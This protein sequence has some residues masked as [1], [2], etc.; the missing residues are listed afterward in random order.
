MLS[1]LNSAE[2]RT[3]LTDVLGG[4][5]GGLKSVVSRAVVPWSAFMSD[6]VIK[7]ENLGKLSRYGQSGFSRA[8]LREA[9]TDAA[10]ALLIL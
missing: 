1:I 7:V 3:A 2:G 5:L 10:S 8:S 4:P 6:I 9:L